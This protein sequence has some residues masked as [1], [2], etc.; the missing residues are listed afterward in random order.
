LNLRIS[1]VKHGKGSSNNGNTARKFFK[2]NPE[3]TAFILGIDSKVV[4][5]FADLLDMFND[6][7]NRPC[8]KKYQ[9]KA[10]DLFGHLTSPP[11]DRFPMTQSVHR[12]LCHGAAFI[13]HFELPV[14]ALSE[15][16]LEAR[17]KYNRSAREHHARKTSMRDNVQDVFNY[18]LYT[19]DPYMYLVKHKSRL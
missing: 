2:K 4:I 3:V 18:L 8:S 17:N 11:L 14:G 12:F 7:L 15:S 5:L 16:A 9:A 6:P 1:E 13:N 10:Q 19:S